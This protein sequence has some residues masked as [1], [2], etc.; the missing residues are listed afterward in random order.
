MLVRELNAN[1]VQLQL[2]QLY[3]NERSIESLKESLDEKNMEARIKKD[4]LSTAE[5]TFRAK[6][7]VLGVLNR[8][9]QQMEREM[10]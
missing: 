3:H 8:D 5:D 9:Q 1:R 6:K 7:K 4:S 2:F 10:K